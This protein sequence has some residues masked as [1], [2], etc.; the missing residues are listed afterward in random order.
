M[1]DTAAYLA[2][3]GLAQAPAA[4]PAG[5]AAVQAAHRQ[6]IPFE[7][8]AVMAGGTIA[9]DSGP[10][11]AKL[12]T[13]RRGGFCFEHNR[14]MADMLGAMGFD[15]A[16][17]LARVLLGSPAET[18][19]R[20]HCLVLVRFD[21]EAW[22]ADAG[23][24]GGYAPPM[25][26]EDGAM[27]GSMD[28]AQHRLRRIGEEGSIPGAWLLERKGPQGPTDGR[29]ASDTLW[30]PQF[31]F[32]LAEVAQADMAMGCHWAA[33]HESSRFTS[34]HVA[35]MCLPDG[36]V[37]LVDRELSLWRAG[38]EPEKRTVPDA[39]EYRRL[40]DHHFGLELSAEEIARLPL[41]RQSPS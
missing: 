7:N 28:G 22:I 27:V 2:R 33:T 14:L 41:W 32:D 31:A 24:G 29:S 17:L 3:I 4:D 38:T 13:A 39:A 26:L 34:L 1:M 35:S 30:E 5:L 20:T 10:V 36:F 8:L 11:F 16:L 23:F 18:T 9:C 40:L 25:P 6:T 12:V 21:E 15:A 37:S 19:P